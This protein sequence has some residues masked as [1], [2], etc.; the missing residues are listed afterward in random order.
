MEL[1]TQ[2]LEAIKEGE[3]VRARAPEIETDCIVLRADLF[4]RVRHLFVDDWS[5]DELLA[6]SARTM[7]SADLG[8]PIP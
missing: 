2:Q 8:E 3:P 1:T 6:I 5:D 7:E 4:E